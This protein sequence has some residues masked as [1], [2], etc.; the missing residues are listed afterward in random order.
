M[1]DAR[2]GAMRGLLHS[3]VPR[4]RHHTVKCRYLKPEKLIHPPPLMEGESLAGR[5]LELGLN[6]AK[7]L[8]LVYFCYFN[9]PP[10]YNLMLFSPLIIDLPH[11]AALRVKEREIIVSR[12]D[13]GK[14]W[15]QHTLEATE[16]A[17]KVLNES[18][19]REGTFNTIIILKSEMVKR[20]IT[21]DVQIWDSWGI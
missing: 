11:F 3:G 12:S 16:E 8:G 2:G 6:N 10:V 18:F 1:V 14:T 19:D 13:N 15:K 7:F 5:I 9:F 17:D 4:A 21:F 20:I